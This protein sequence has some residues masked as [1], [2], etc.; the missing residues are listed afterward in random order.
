MG[1]L[2]F[3]VCLLGWFGSVVLIRQSYSLNRLFV[4]LIMS[5][6]LYVSFALL[7]ISSQ[8]PLWVWLGL[9]FIP[10]FLIAYGY[11]YY[12]KKQELEKAKNDDKIKRVESV[13]D[14][15]S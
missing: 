1:L 5:I 12:E 3:I 4:F 11:R 15:D 14:A 8:P 6:W 10:I 13:L 9:G 2:I 7:V